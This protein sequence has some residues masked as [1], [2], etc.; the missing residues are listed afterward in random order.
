ME[1]FIGRTKNVLNKYYERAY[2]SDRLGN[3]EDGEI[4]NLVKET[5]SRIKKHCKSLLARLDKYN[6]KLNKE[7]GE[8][9]YDLK[10]VPRAVYRKLKDNPLVRYALL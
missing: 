1:E 8:V 7:T 5:P 6:V 9:T 4:L 3:L 2:V 10:L